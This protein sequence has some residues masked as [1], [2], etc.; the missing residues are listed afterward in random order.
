MLIF[1]ERLNGYQWVGIV[2]TLF[3]FYWF[4]TAGKLEGISFKKN[5]WVW[6]IIGAAILASISG[7]YDKF[8]IA[9]IDRIATQAWFSFYQV[10]ILL[11][12]VLFNEKIRKRKNVVFEWRW[13][14]LFIGIT[15]VIA[16][17]FY[18]YALSMEGSLI[19]VIAALR[20][21][22]VLVTFILGSILFNEKNL[23]KKG[24]YLIGILIG[25]LFISLGTL[26]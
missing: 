26:L 6:C 3:F 8:I 22:S 14:I 11:P 18:F 5:K 20:R 10:A 13:T 25:I 4:S 23:K 19:A 1:H 9:R 15:L 12:F 7:L 2:I 16:D 24:L 21:G 17:Y